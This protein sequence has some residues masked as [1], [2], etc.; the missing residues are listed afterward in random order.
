MTP[1]LSQKSSGIFRVDF[2]DSAGE[3]RR[4]TLKTRDRA[5][6][7]ARMWDTIQTHEESLKQ[8]STSSL[9]S[10]RKPAIGV[11]VNDLFD[12]AEKTVWHPDNAK[13]QGTIRSNL[14]VLRPMIG[15]VLAKDVTYTRLEQLTEDL[16]AKGYAPATVKRKMDMVSK[17]LRMATIWSDAEGRPLLTAKPTMPSIRVAN[18]KDRILELDEEQQVFLAIAAR[19]D[20]EPGRQWFRFEALVRF[21]LDT[22]ARLGEALNA[23]P[24]NISYMGGQAYVTFPRYRTKSDKPRT[25]PLTGRLVEALALVGEHAGRR[26]GETLPVYFPLSHGTAWY[27]WDN[28]R[29][30]LKRLGV[31]IEDVTLH[32]LRHTCLTRLARGGMDLLRLQQWAGHSDPKITAER[33]VHLTPGNLT[34]GLDILSPS[35]PASHVIVISTEAGA[36]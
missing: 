33:Y 16:K 25:V 3:R 21:L 1:T 23:G 26:R 6:A 15:D 27:M 5:T 31:D 22:G 8:P 13:S 14:R 34:G 29:E 36:N 17:A 28:I 32:T 10:P 4:L 20:R 11:T 7:K 35:N 19:K 2:I 9:G 30:D 18:T 24:Q 12:R